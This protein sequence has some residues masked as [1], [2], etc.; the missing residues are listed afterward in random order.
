MIRRTPRSTRTDTL[1]PYTTLFRS[2]H[3]ELLVLD[4]GPPLGF[5]VS[6]QFALWH[7]RLA[8]GDFLLAYT[9]GVTEAFN[10]DN[11]AYG[12]ERLLAMAAPGHGALEHCRRLVAAVNRFA[13][14]A[15]Q[16]DDITVL[17]HRLGDDSAEYAEAQHQTGA[18]PC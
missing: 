17:E 8:S 2:G 15:P 9:D 16:S 18:V 6:E 14:G 4:N 13:D 3:A 12:S 1:F 11:E 5:E 7:C 10:H